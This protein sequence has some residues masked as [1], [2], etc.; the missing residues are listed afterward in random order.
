MIRSSGL[1]ARGRLARFALLPIALLTLALLPPG[2]TAAA[3]TSALPDAPE[4]AS[5]LAS[6]VAVQGPAQAAEPQLEVDLY[7]A[8]LALRT[9]PGTAVKAELRRGAEVIDSA[10]GAADAAGLARLTWG[11][12]LLGDGRAAISLGGSPTS[13]RPGDQLRILR[14][15]GAPLVVDVPLLTATVD[16]GVDRISGQGPA[17]AT[18]SFALSAGGGAAQAFEAVAD[19]GGRYQLDLAGRLDLPEEGL[20]GQL[21]WLSGESYRFRLALTNL[22]AEAVLAA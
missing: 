15:G 19:A 6:P 9:L 20:S 1:P 18:L 5:G 17:G 7:G 2:S 13:I 4:K 14:R 3:R 10:A 22:E 16:A 11:S 21:T 8:G 12:Y